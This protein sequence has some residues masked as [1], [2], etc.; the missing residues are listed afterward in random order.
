MGTF[1]SCTLLICLLFIFQSNLKQFLDYVRKCD[2]DKINKMTIRGLDPNFH[3]HETGGKF[4][5][6]VCIGL[7]LCVMDYDL[8]LNGYL[9]S[10]FLIYFSPAEVF[11]L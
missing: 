2:I 10:V 6:A 3:E 11:M 9:V 1:L 5:Y 8:S 7:D 4:E